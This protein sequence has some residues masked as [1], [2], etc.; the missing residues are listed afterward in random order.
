MNVFW[1]DQV[2]LLELLD[3]SHLLDLGDLSDLQQSHPHGLAEKYEIRTDGRVV[4][5][6]R[7]H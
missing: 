4:A 5:R 7:L 6:Q 3:L 1:N 2:D